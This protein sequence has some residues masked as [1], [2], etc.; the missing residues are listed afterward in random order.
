MS[1]GDPPSRFSGR[2]TEWPGV[3]AVM[4]RDPLG[5]LAR[6]HR[7]DLMAI[8]SLAILASTTGLLPK[9]IAGLELDRSSEG[10]LLWAIALGIVYQWAAFVIYS[11]PDRIAY[12]AR[13]REL[14]YQ[15]RGP[16]EVPMAALPAAAR[17]LLDTVLPF[18]LAPL[19][20]T[21]LSWRA[22]PALGNPQ[23]RRADRE[24]ACAELPPNSWP[25]PGLGD[26]LAAEAQA[27]RWRSAR[28]RVVRALRGRPGLRLERRSHRQGVV[29][30]R[31]IYRGP[32]QL[33]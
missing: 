26:I 5:E 14:G 8:S 4:L 23:S 13:L 28:F 7:R 12:A 10:A 3:G 16:G 29:D 33:R 30:E 27:Q 25:R 11:W 19:A 21:L 20:I 17:G 1:A 9:S 24:L 6:R 15:P 18:L 22:L 32:S 2:R 31:A